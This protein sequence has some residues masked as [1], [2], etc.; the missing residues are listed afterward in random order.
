[1]NYRLDMAIF[2]KCIF[3]WSVIM[4]IVSNTI[5][6]DL[7]PTCQS[8]IFTGGLTTLMSISVALLTWSLIYMTKCSNKT[9]DKVAISY[10]IGCGVFGL[11]IISVLI[12]VLVEMGKNDDCSDHKNLTI[13]TLVVNIIFSIS[14]VGLLIGGKYVSYKS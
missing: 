13:T 9:N 4:L 7:G 2:V 6:T 11:A 5:F 10:L 12:G 14:I 8:G 3:I 1:M